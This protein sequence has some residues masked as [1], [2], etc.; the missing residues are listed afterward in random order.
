MTT[1]TFDHI[2]AASGLDSINVFWLNLAPS[3][4]Q[5]VITCFGCA[6]TGYYRAMG[7]RIIEKFFDDA[8]T[9][10]LVTKLGIT[11]LL[12]VRKTDQL[13]LGKI[14]RAIKAHRAAGP[15]ACKWCSQ[16]YVPIESSVSFAYV[17]PDTPVGRVICTKPQ[18][19]GTPGQHETP[20]GPKL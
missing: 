1:L 16:G 8:D 18:R 7:G 2:P 12:K 3:E 20:E 15:A 11:P 5:V 13:Y 9:D 4:G 19:V 17:H 10:Y 6:W 14:I